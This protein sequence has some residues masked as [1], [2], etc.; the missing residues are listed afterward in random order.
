MKWQNGLSDLAGTRKQ[1][2]SRSHT[3]MTFRQSHKTGG[4]TLLELLVVILIISVLFA[5]AAPGWLAFANNQRLN[6][7][8]GQLAQVI[9]NAQSEARRTQT[10]RAIVFDNNNNQPRVAVVGLV[11]DASGD[12][13]LATIP[14]A[15]A[16]TNWEILGG[17]NINQNLLRMQI[18]GSPAI[19]SGTAAPASGFFIF[20][21][22]GTSWRS[23]NAATTTTVPF[24][25]R[26]DLIPNPNNRRCISVQ[27]LLGSLSEGSGTA[28]CP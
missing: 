3:L 1:R 14:T 24:T 10:P 4:F 21:S 26:V 7:A 12:P 23:T 13:N 18:T 28:Q 5:I 6:T 25:V 9:R 17:G 20:N 11:P 15:A 19:P 16:I 22:D 2:R 27:T 8:S